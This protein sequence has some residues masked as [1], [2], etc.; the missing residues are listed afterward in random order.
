MANTWTPAQ[1]AAIETHG[2]TLLVSA[3]A[4]SGKTSTLTERIIRDISRDKD[5]RDI[6]KMLIVTFTRSAASDLK[7]KISSALG[8]AIAESPRNT[9]LQSQLIKLGSAKICTIDSFYLD[10]LR[11]NF[12]EAGL[13]S[14][15]RIAD[16]AEIDLIAKRIMQ[17]TVDDL[18]ASETG[19]ALFCECFAG[20]K[21]S[22][23]SVDVFLDL[24]SHT[25]DIPEGIEFLSA[26]AKDLK[27]SISRDFMSSA[28]GGLISENML[29]VLRDFREFYSIECERFFDEPDAASFIKAF[30]HDKLLC[31]RLIS[32]LITPSDTSYTDI[33]SELNSISYPSLTFS[34]K[35][36]GLIDTDYYK[37]VR[38]DFKSNINSFKKDFFTLSKENISK[39]MQIT[40]QNVD[41]LDKT[42]YEGLYNVLFDIHYLKSEDIVLGFKIF[43]SIVK[44]MNKELFNQFI[45]EKN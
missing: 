41:L 9:H 33:Q 44:P 21:D 35:I 39:C 11:R 20:I 10:I 32:L 31:E 12:S 27:D 14:S 43:D 8:G 37:Y 19:Y 1:L 36:A 22:E 15:F 38:N 6:S 34:K 3:A 29:D 28:Y 30:S 4:G 17:D 25:L 26:H 16:S 18:Y 2:K 40:A 5:P 42:L 23:S 24:Y 13:S 45:K 7:A